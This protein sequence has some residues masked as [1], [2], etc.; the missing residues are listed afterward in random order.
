MNDNIISI[1]HREVKEDMRLNA[2]TD[3]RLNS[4]EAPV[5]YEMFNGEYDIMKILK[6]SKDANETY[7][8]S[9]EHLKNKYIASLKRVLL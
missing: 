8:V 2:L 5:K 9:K 3:F 6:N 1:I 4:E 7:L